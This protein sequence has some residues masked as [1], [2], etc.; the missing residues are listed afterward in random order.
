[1][2]PNG[3]NTMLAVGEKWNA[4]AHKLPR[5]GGPGDQPEVKPVLSR[6]YSSYLVPHVECDIPTLVTYFGHVSD[7][8]RSRYPPLSKIQL[9]SDCCFLPPSHMLGERYCLTVGLAEAIYKNFPQDGR[10]A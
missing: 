8:A 6:G 3:M 7:N 4:R 2:N 1:M 10:T 5:E 9:G